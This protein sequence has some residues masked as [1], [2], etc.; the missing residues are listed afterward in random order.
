MLPTVWE[1]V[2]KRFG[3]AEWLYSLCLAAASLSNIFFGPLF[4]VVYDKTHATKLLVL[5]SIA[6]GV[7]GEGI[8][9]IT[10]ESMC[11]QTHG[12]HAQRYTHTNCTW[13]F[14]C[15]LYLL[16]WIMYFIAVSGYMVL[17]GRLLIGMCVV[18]LYIDMKFIFF[19]L[20]WRAFSGIRND[21]QWRNGPNH[22]QKTENSSLYHVNRCL[23]VWLCNR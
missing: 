15:L 23:T 12:S 14:Y 2:V 20:S 10:S 8:Q 19:S 1:Y 7:T 16:G 13:L 18:Q 11:P 9:N 17:A 22:N 6:C 3:G 5:T 4:G 21:Y